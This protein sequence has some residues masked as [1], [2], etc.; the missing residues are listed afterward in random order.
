MTVKQVKSSN[1]E[2]P[3][4]IRILRELNELAEDLIQKR[5]QL[6]HAER[7]LQSKRQRLS[8]V[9]GQFRVETLGE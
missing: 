5:S 4:K 8:D 3:R 6:K 2:K 9:L 1:I 7:E